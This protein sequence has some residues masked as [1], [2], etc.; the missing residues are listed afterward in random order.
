MCG[1]RN[2]THISGSTGRRFGL[3][4]FLARTRRLRR[5]SL[6][7]SFLCAKANIS[8]TKP[9]AL[10][11]SVEPVSEEKKDLASNSG[12][13]PTRPKLELQ[14]QAEAA[15]DFLVDAGSRNPQQIPGG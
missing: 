7:A 3:S 4:I 8:R 5:S 13:F 10:G 9:L 6:R 12:V 2:Q 14:F 15:D 1:F 11:C